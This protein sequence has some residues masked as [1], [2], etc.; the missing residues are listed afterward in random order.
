MSRKK[1]RKMHVPVWVQI[2]IIL[3]ILVGIPV[4]II[5]FQSRQSGLDFGVTMRS[6]A[7]RIS[8]R[9][10]SAA[11]TEGEFTDFPV[12]FEPRAIGNPAEGYPM[13]SHL[14][15]YDMTGN[16]LL[17]VVVA[18]IQN[19]SIS[20]ILQEPVDVFNE[21][22]IATNIIA[23][24]HLQII[25][26]NKNGHPDILVGVLG[27]LFPNNDPIGSIVYLENT[28]DLNFNKHVL[29]ENIAR[30]SDVRAGDMNGNGLLD[31]VVAQFGYDDGEVRWMENLGNLEFRSHILQSLSGAI[32]V[33]IHDFNENGHLDFAVLISQE[34]QEIYIFTNDGSGNFTPNLIWG[35]SNSDFGSSSLTMFDL[36]QNGRMDLLYTNGD[37]FDYIPPRPRP[38]HG[39]HWLENK[40]DLNFEIQRLAFFGGATYAQ[41]FDATHNG[42]MDIFAVSCFNLWDNPESQSLIWFQN[43]GDMQFTRHRISNNPTHLLKLKIGDFN[44]NGQMDFVTGGMHIFPPHDRIG[45]ITLWTNKWAEM[46]LDS[47]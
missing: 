35:S 12:F 5:Y 4:S 6:L 13:I 29:I 7:K 24:S 45:R 26:F 40:G 15:P 10:R 2:S 32:N 44:N 9:D 20:I 11:F 23:P 21:I 36:N 16:G 42:N 28:G 30:V 17:D 34:W 14:E 19:N 41:A 46:D 43:T 18:D 1:S 22:T 47:P 3:I 38:W 37:A 33:E 39:V 27:M 31:L 25:D 8:D